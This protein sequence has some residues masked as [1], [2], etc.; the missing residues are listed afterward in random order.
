MAP[1]AEGSDRCH[2][3]GGRP[4]EPHAPGPPR[5][6][7]PLDSTAIAYHLRTTHGLDIEPATIRQWGTRGKI[8]RRASTQRAA[9]ADAKGPL[10]AQDPPAPHYRYDLAEVVAFLRARGDITE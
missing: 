10:P 2:A 9:T 1:T 6:S 8:S 4:A 7:I 5:R 3:H